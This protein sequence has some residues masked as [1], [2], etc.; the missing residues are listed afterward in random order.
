MAIFAV[1]IFSTNTSCRSQQK[2][3]SDSQG[4]RMPGPRAIIYSTKKDYSS[5]VPVMLND[6]R[7]AVVSYPGIRDITVNGQLTKPTALAGG[8]WLDNRGIG[9]NVAFISLT[10]EQYAALPATPNSDELFKMLVDKK[11]LRRM[12]MGKLK[13]EYADVVPVMNQII[14]SGDFSSLTRLK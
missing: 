14:L 12:Y 8:Y 9:P 6:E 4:I 13:A 1:S 5:L 11:P 10:Y 2:A 7:T 3:S